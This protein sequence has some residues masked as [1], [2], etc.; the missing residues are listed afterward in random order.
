MQGYVKKGYRRKIDVLEATALYH[1]GHSFDA[2]GSRFGVSRQAVYASLVRAGVHA[3][4]ESEMTSRLTDEQFAALLKSIGDRI[5]ASQD[6]YWRAES[7]RNSVRSKTAV[8]IR[9]GRLVPQPCEVCGTTKR[10]ANGQRGVHAHH[11]DYSQPLSVRW[12]CPKHHKAW[13]LVSRPKLPGTE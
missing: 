8:A 5:A 11:D 1:A 12:L 6:K 4:A 7:I 2:I 3:V 9:T 10:L 13:H